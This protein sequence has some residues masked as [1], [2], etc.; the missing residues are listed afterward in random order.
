M[1][2][3][4][5]LSA[6]YD[7]YGKLL[8][9]KQQNYFIDYYFNN[10]SLKEISEN[11]NISRNAVFKQLKNIEEKLNF[12]ES[13]LKLYKKNEKLTKIIG[14]INDEKIKKQLENL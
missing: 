9:E 5:Y 7:Y 13:K 12:Y 4:I 6:L 8:T 11:Q 3:Y 14:Q 1:D 2:K 10:L